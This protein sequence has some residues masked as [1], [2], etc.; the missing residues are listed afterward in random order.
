MA[1]EKVIYTLE[2]TEALSTASLEKLKRETQKDETLQLLQNRHRQGWPHHK[3]QVDLRMT[4]FWRVRHTV[5]ERWHF[6][7][8]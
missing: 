7:C 4:Q 6:V 5:S 8:W 2:P 3:K 1:D